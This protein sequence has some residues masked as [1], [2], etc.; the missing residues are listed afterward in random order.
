MF[1]PMSQKGC[2]VV[3]LFLLQL[4]V[5]ALLLHSQGAGALVVLSMG[6]LLSAPFADKE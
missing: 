3:A 4:S 6:F 5:G 2:I 1:K